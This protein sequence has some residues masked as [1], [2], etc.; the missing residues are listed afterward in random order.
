MFS[1]KY[2]QMADGGI[3]Y[4]E[5]VTQQENW[6]KSNK[7]SIVGIM[8][9]GQDVKVPLSSFAQGFQG[10]FDIDCQFNGIHGLGLY[11]IFDKHYLIGQD[12]N[13]AK[14]RVVVNL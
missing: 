14:L 9:T 11:S 8:P 4:S 7:L 3:T 13:N 6:D 12:V 1:Y 2:N 10:V 5:Y